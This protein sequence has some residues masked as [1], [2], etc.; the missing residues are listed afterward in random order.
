MYRNIPSTKRMAYK[1]LCT[2][3]IVHEIRVYEVVTY[4]V[5]VVCG[6]SYIHSSM[7]VTV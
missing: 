3:M 2:A 7:C 6:L 1:T 4:I 5:N